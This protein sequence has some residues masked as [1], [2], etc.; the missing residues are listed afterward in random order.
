MLPE[1]SMVRRI[2][3][4][5]FLAGCGARTELGVPGLPAVTVVS[6]GLGYGH[7]CAV[8]SDGTAACWGDDSNGQLGNAPS[9]SP[10][11]TSLPLASPTGIAAISAGMY[12]TCAVLQ[13]GALWCWGGGE[14]GQ[15]A[16]GMS[17]VA[18]AAPAQVA[19]G[20]TGVSC[21]FEYTCVV[22]TDGTV[23]CAGE[24]GDAMLGDGSYTTVNT[25]KAVAG[26]S[27]AVAVAASEWDTCALIEDGSVQCWG[28]GYLGNGTDEMNATTPVHVQGLPGPATQIAVGQSHACALLQGGAVACWGYGEAGE[29][30]LGVGTTLELLPAVVPGVSAQ[31]ISAAHIHTCALLAD[32][33]AS[34]WGTDMAYTLGPFTP[35]AVPGLSSAIAIASG[36][37]HN[38]AVLE[39]GRVVCW[40]N[41][42]V[43]QLGDGTTTNS[44]APVKVLGL[45]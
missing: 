42:E 14:G 34:C 15:L 31:A 24:N 38:C 12:H 9:T 29:L 41:N 40:G 3:A 37:A 16:N 26:V 8:L 33:T 5:L 2:L 25:L 35:V 39:S 45:P 32:G 36:D 43:G 20:I 4:F 27:G 19:T 23:A 1:S 11:T 28:T 30:G 44:A 18:H 7:S 10:Q 13:D 17:W 21:G 6:L 22:R